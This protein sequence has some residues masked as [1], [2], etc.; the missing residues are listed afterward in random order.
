MK[1][2]YRGLK[3]CSEETTSSTT[4]SLFHAETA[5]SSFSNWIKSVLSSLSEDEITL[6]NVPIDRIGTH[7][8]RKGACTSVFGVTDGPDSDTVK[9]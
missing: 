2:R 6:I 7:S 5:D 3:I 9:L 1:I 8:M 4:F